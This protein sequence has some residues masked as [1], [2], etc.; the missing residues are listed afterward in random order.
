MR[1]LL[2]LVLAC[3]LL[4]AVGCTDGRTGNDI[5]WTEPQEF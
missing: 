3:A 5:E 4:G 1:K 2:L